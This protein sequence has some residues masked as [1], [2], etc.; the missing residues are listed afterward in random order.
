MKVVFCSLNSQYIHSSLAPWC[1]LAGLRAFGEGAVDGTVVEGTVNEPLAAVVERVLA[2]RP[3]AVGL[4]CYIWNIAQMRQLAAAIK[5]ERPDCFVFAGG[6]EVSYCA[7]AVLQETPALD[8]VVCG[9]GERP[10]AALLTALSKGETLA[11]LPGVCYRTATDIVTAEPF[12]T[13]EEPP[14]P[15]VPEYFEAL[16]GRIAYLETSRGC[17]FSC[18]FC[19]SGRCGGVRFYPLERVKRELLLLANS[20]TQTVKLVDRTFNAD[21]RRAK[22]IFSFLIEEYGKGIPKTVC[23]HFEIGGDLLDEDTI[24]L[25]SEAPAGLFQMEI[26]LQSF[27]EPTL[28]AIRRKTDTARLTDT[29]RK[30]VSA[31]NIHIHIDLIA[32]LPGEDLATFAAGVNTAVALQPHMLQLG[33]LKLLHGAAMRENP[34]DFPCEYRREPPY[35]VT[36]TP[37]LSEQDLAL[38]HGV[39]DALDRLYNSGRFRR[40]LRYLTAELSYTPYEVFSQLAEELG[41]C[42]A[43]LSLDE[44]TEKLYRCLSRWEGVEAA[45]LRDEMVRD[46]LS[47]NPGGLLPAVLQYQPEQVKRLKRLADSDPRF[48]R[49]AGVRRG[50]A[51]LEG[52]DVLVY[53]DQTCRHP[54]TGL[55]ELRYFEEACLSRD[56]QA[57]LFDLDGT[58]TDPA[59]GIANSVGYAL[60][61]FG[62]TVEDP[63]EL[64]RFIGPPLLDSFQQFYGLSPEQ[65]RQALNYYREYYAVDGIYQNVVYEGMRELLCDLKRHGYR[66]LVATSK[67][68]TYARRIFDAYDLTRYFD[69]IAGSDMSEKRADKSLVVAYALE[70]AALPPSARAIMVGDR[71]FDV[72]GA[73]Q[74]GLPC[75]G[76]LFGY[77]DRPELEAA[78][79]AYIAETVEELRKLFL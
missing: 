48:A 51:C 74:Q 17:P 63:R 42:P 21:R 46:R 61:K 13:G 24:V 31:G 49:P 15:Y 32:G 3:D 40:T 59:E 44:Y 34:A 16:N 5:A 70:Q 4:S 50:A 38:L 6:P 25:L 8:A 39:E 71:H 58:I 20:G 41:R 62:I 7:E 57:I 14:S 27:H 55:Y 68:E 77:G 37:W 47:A 65:A 69:V 29:I 9:E 64:Y 79:A 78:G 18:A 56:Y 22:E 75:V 67:P 19:L 53:A 23:F 2:C 54:V 12:V 28:A 66:V 45:R 76:V 73:A 1:L 30:L 35:E 60:Q 43:K 11:D 33:F 36:K 26:G 72:A 52:G 10:V